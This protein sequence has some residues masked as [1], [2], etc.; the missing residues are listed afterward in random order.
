MVGE[1]RAAWAAGLPAWAQH[2][3]I[4]DQL[5]LAA[6]QFGKRLLALRRIENVVLLHFLPG[7]FA[8]L[9][10]ERI[11]SVG[12]RFFLGQIGL[13][14][15]DPFIVRNDLVRLHETILSSL[16]NWPASSSRFRRRRALARSRCGRHSERR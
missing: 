3:M 16:I 2:E 11:A 8:A 4:D 13:A 7:Q 15:G 14:R 1:K 12:K 9:A 10:A 6:E 5:T